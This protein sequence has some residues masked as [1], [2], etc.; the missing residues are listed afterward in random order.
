L[1]EIGSK[2]QY[3]ECKREFN[4]YGY[5]LITPENEYKHSHE[6]VTLVD[7]NGYYGV[8]SY[9]IFRYDHAFKPFSTHN[10]YTIQNI[11]KYIKINNIDS[12]LVSKKYNGLDR[13]LR[14]KCSCGNEFE[15]SWH[16]F[17]CANQTKCRACNV[18]SYR[19]KRLNSEKDLNRV[20]EENECFLFK[21]EY[22][23]NK[24]RLHVIDKDGYKGIT[25]YSRL[26]YGQYPMKFH[27]QNPYTL[28]NIKTYI[29]I[30]NID[31]KLLS[32]NY[33]NNKTDKLKFQCKCGN[34][35]MCSLDYF[36]RCEKTRCDVCMK[37]KSNIESK[38][39]NWLK[40]NEIQF[41]FQYRIEGC[42][43]KRVL[44]FDFAIFKNTNLFGLIEV[45]GQQHYSDIDTHFFSKKRTKEEKSEAKLRDFIKTN[46]CKRN[47][48]K[49]LRLKQFYFQSDRY[50][51]ELKSFVFEEV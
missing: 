9:D 17:K 51:R 29:K 41:I 12:I 23:S 14:F 3:E 15:V 7:E 22:L 27:A 44:P 5:K 39:E 20:L 46:Y 47:N 37:N 1:N 28:E 10:P 18:E 50:I 19:E 32:T 26:N 34:T 8:I 33:N 43:H 2:I 38:T 48:I 35:F 36:I 4:K 42:K 16:H 31:C 11:K 49:L 30:N 6:K 45:D 25:C 21:G 40:E 13:K 24:S